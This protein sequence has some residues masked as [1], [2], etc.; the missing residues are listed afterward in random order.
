M[1]N[2]SNKLS[3]QPVPRTLALVLF[4]YFPFGGMQANFLRIAEACLARGHRV[5]VYTLDWQGE[6]PVGLNINFVEVKKR[7]NIHRY[8]QF[9]GRIAD[10]MQGQRYDLVMGF[11]RM[12]GL[13]LYYAADPCFVE[14]VAKTRPWY[15]RFGA[16]YRH[17]KA[18]ERALFGPQSRAHILALSPFQIAEY[19]HNYATDTA[20]FSL[21]PPGVQPRYRRNSEASS[22]GE[23]LRRQYRLDNQTQLLLMVGSGFERKGFDR[24]LRAFAALPEKVRAQSHMMIVGKGRDKS[25]RRLAS[26][27][28]VVQQLTLI[29]GSHEI[30]AFIQ[31]ADV[32]LHPARS[33]N[34]GNVIVE[35]ICGGLPVLCSG[36][37]GYALHVERADAGLVMEEP[38]DQAQMN[39]SVLLMLDLQSQK[40]WAQNAL[41]YA[42]KEDLYS[43]IEAIVAAIE[44]RATELDNTSV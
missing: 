18:F 2:A 20:R 28:G 40:Q 14:R 37:C 30:P 6:R 13:D 12:P 4:R 29:P 17:F 16:R 3:A 10:I 44:W 35:A 33:E 31:A 1:Q 43:R 5:D 25:L 7:Q 36:T 34:T 11:N 19:Q 22:L 38:F 42:D 9:S 32:L 41:A 15:Y 24:G 8:E 27:L 23:D 26:R 39:D 21:L